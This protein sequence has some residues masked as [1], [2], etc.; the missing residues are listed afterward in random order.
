MNVK[1]YYQIPK[2]LFKYNLTATDINVFM[3]LYD[4]M[5]AGQAENSI[6]QDYARVK[7]TTISKKLGMS[8]IHINHIIHKLSRLNLIEIEYY[9]G[10][11]TYYIKQFEKDFYIRY[12]KELLT[13]GYLSP[14]VKLTYCI[15]YDKMYNHISKCKKN[16]TKYD[17]Y[18]H[19][20]ESELSEMLHITDRQTR[21][22]IKKM[23]KHGLLSVMKRGNKNYYSML[24]PANIKT[25][26]EIYLESKQKIINTVN[27]T[28]N[29][30]ADTVNTVVEKVDNKLNEA[31]NSIADK[32]TNTINTA[33]NTANEK[34]ESLKDTIHNAKEKF[35]KK[36]Q[37][38]DKT[39]TN[40]NTIMS[41]AVN[42]K[43]MSEFM[44]KIKKA[45]EET[46]KL[47]KQMK[48]KKLSINWK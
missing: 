9:N 22:I 29:A 26:I 44:E 48:E 31:V 46:D 34:L 2:E 24:P 28:V 38:Q 45:N 30:I 39:T 4:L 12:P 8:R 13:I 5:R 32:T 23:V 25:D 7:Q 33:V 10:M 27:T 40:N 17:G 6:T 35:D 42:N 15:M 36:I 3:Y 19:M 21:N 18:F 43:A 37:E 20:A 16:N 47:Y 14:V 11:N 1:K 41:N